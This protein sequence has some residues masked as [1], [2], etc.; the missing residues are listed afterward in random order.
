MDH[1]RE[2]RD[3]IPMSPQR[4]KSFD[5]DNDE[6]MWTDSSGD[7]DNDSDDSIPRLKGCRYGSD[8][9]YPRSH[10]IVQLDQAGIMHCPRLWEDDNM[11]SLNSS[12]DSREDESTQPGPLEVVSV[13]CNRRVASKE[14][15]RSVATKNA[16]SRSA[17]KQHRKESPPFQK[18]T[19]SWIDRKA[20]FE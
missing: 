17:Q 12:E 20:S 11:I 4:V 14:R 18:E 2:L 1:E 7:N 19:A 6:E 10:V 8:E 3:A 5:D 15:K 9:K 16:S 13:Q